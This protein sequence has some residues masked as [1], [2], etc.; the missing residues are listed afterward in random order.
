MMIKVVV[1]DAIVWWRV[2]ML[3][4]GVKA[5]RVIL[6]VSVLLLSATFGMSCR[7]SPLPTDASYD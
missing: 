4:P 2:Y 1:G 6:G 5:R 7:R 3:W